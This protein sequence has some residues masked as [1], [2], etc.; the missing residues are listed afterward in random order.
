MRKLIILLLL[1]LPQLSCAETASSEKKYPPYPDVWGYELPSISTIYKMDDGDIYITFSIDAAKT[2][3]KD[4]SSS[5]D[6][7]KYFGHSFFTGLQRVFTREEYN[8]FGNRYNKMRVSYR[9][10]PKDKPIQDY[11]KNDFNDGSRVVKEGGGLG[12]CAATIPY[13][14]WIELIDR[15]GNVISRKTPLY[16]LDKSKK[17]TFREPCVDIAG[18]V[19]T[20]TRQIRFTFIPLE[21][22]TFLIYEQSGKAIIRFDKKLKTKFKLNKNKIFLIDTAVIDKIKAREAQKNDPDSIEY[23]Q[24]VRDAVAN[25]L[26]NL[27]RRNNP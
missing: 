2:G 13:P 6:A 24:N 11:F 1:A 3:H 4:S 17:D 22:D 7:R 21:D 15:D 20:Q 23:H 10:S 8:T 12:N 9:A 14:Y 19:L 26:L 27:Q 18:A 16:L 5:N 25:Y